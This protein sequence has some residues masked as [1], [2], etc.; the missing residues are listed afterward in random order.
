MGLRPRYVW[1]C[2]L[3]L[4][5]TASV[6]SQSLYTDPVLNQSQGSRAFEQ[7]QARLQ[8]GINLYSQSK[9][10]EAVLE[11]RRVQA[12]APGR[13]LR[14][15]A[16]FWIS[17]CELSAGEYEESLQD[18]AALEE[19]DPGNRRLVELPYHRGRALYYLGRYNEA[20]VLFRVYMDSLFAKSGLSQPDRSKV[21]A[22][23]F[24]TGECLFSM[25]QLDRAGDV[26]Q[27]IT[28]EYPESPKYEASVYRL[29]LI[30]QKTVEIE[31]LGLLK[32]SHEDS[33]RNMEEFR[34]RESAY[35]QALSASQKRLED[36]NTRYR[37]ELTQAEERI[38]SL[39]NA[40]RETSSTKEKARDSASVERLKS[41]KRNAEEL[42]R[43]ISGI[44]R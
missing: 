38:R 35:D 18:M 29:A 6:N 27:L 31:L 39:E 42:E 12:E 26:F 14:A 11:L 4:A 44:G 22:A 40:L 36:S 7:A 13:E 9:W 5:I 37:E 21:A 25:G 10:R 20:I 43:Y 19:T 1:V 3:F 8:S 34:R 28:E 16:L 17:L 33:L 15:E 23:H 24:W 30:N 32:W 41:M 2:L